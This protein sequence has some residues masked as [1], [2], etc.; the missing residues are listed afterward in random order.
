MRSVADDPFLIAATRTIV[1]RFAPERIVLFGSRARGDHQ[2]E[3]D[4]DLIVV[5]E[6]PLERGER[7]DAI[8]DVLPD[9]DQGVDVIVYTPAEFEISRHD[10]G[11]LAF[12]GETEGQIL[13]DRN[14]A[15]WPRSVREKPHGPPPSLIYWIARAESDVAVMAEIFAGSRQPDAVTFHA[16]QAAEKFLKAALIWSHVPP[17]RTH[18]LKKLLARSVAE[19]R[20][21]PRLIRACKFLDRLWPKMRYPGKPMPSLR[22]TE[23]AMAAASDVRAAVLRRM[24]TP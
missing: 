6:T 2:P 20:D 13:Y 23:A 16:H 4:Y 21:D 5:L 22:E 10:V 1:D 24:E 14:P 12:A 18:R 11:A 15:R 17:P 7:D 3:S 9:A 8:R 19:L